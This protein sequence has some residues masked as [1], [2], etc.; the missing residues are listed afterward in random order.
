MADRRLKLAAVQAAPVFLD[1][2][3]TVEKACSLIREAGEAG[4]DVMGFPEGFI[5][6]HPLWYHF[7]PATSREAF[8]FSKRLSQNAVVVPG[9]ET[10]RLRAAAAAAGVFV[11]M[12]ICEAVPDRP[13]TLFNTLL[14][15]DSEGRLVGRHRK[16]VPTLGER[17]VHAPGDALGLRAYPSADARV[18]GLMCG[19][20]SNPLA[21]FA[22]D[23]DGASLHVASWPSHF[24]LG[25]D[26]RDI[27]LMASRSL[28]YQVKA[29]V[30]NAVGEV[31]DQML[32]ELAATDEHRRFLEQRCGG[33]SI[34]GPWGQVVAGPMDAGEGILYADVDL[35]DLIVPKGI[36]D[37]G[38]HYNRFDLLQLQ[39][40]PG[41]YENVTRH[42]VPS[43]SG[44]HTDEQAL[45]GL[46]QRLA[47]DQ[48]AHLGPGADSLVPAR[49]ELL[50]R[51]EGT[52]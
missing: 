48:Q 43:V 10:E 27:I 4:A 9:P 30:I 50:G 34:I 51:T 31:S 20:N 13:G 35:D 44:G 5:P 29:F 19:E 22:L 8:S 21:T 39:L 38:G 17:L 36:Q 18:S 2:E 12:G 23:A 52:F 45:H 6:T 28:A 11:V 14:F 26:M 37:F 41:A 7:H 3:A 42:G 49:P 46:A 32:T 15:I 25:V 33:A 40:H 47:R 1:R 24:N 16:L